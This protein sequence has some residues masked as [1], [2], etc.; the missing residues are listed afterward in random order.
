MLQEKK[1]QRSLSLDGLFVCLF[2]AV[3]MK[4]KW[5]NRTGLRGHMHSKTW[6][7]TI[8]L[9]LLSL[10]LLFFRFILNS[11]SFF[12]LSFLTHFLGPLLT[13]TFNASSKQSFTLWKEPSPK[14]I[15]FFAKILFKRRSILNK[16]K[17][18]VTTSQFDVT[19]SYNRHI[20]NRFVLTLPAKQKSYHSV[21]FNFSK[22]FFFLLCV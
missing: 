14:N 12:F 8:F 21:E 3:K 9:C 16:T 5:K 22:K 1:A 18:I 19:S 20:W 7:A 13:H 10:S 2:A 15:F 4:K 11:V 6:A 17:Q